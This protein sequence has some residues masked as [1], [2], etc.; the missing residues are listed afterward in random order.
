MHAQALGDRPSSRSSLRLGA[1]L[2]H[3]R[4][5]LT[6]PSCLSDLGF[7]S[8]E[9]DGPIHPVLDQGGRSVGKG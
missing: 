7:H 4:S 3:K 6:R 8:S 5:Y 2:R 1:D 9:G